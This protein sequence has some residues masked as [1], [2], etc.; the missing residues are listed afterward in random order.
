VV[1]DQGPGIPPDKLEK[2]F[3]RFYTDRPVGTKFGNNSG[4]GLS[5]VRQITETHRG[6]VWA[7][8][9]MIDGQI[10]GA[11]FVVELPPALLDI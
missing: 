6:S 4:L 1:E 3:Q 10:A 2:I 5:I 11:R 8:N 9:R 7:E